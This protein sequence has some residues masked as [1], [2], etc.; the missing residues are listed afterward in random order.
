MSQVKTAKPQVKLEKNEPKM[1]AREES[2]IQM[3]V[4]L[5]S[6]K[7]VEQR[8]MEEET[9]GTAVT[10]GKRRP[11]IMK[12]KLLLQVGEFDHCKYPLI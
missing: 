11:K 12:P 4:P 2:K 1:K 10:W 5:K 7:K 3:A 9:K 8:K 6:V